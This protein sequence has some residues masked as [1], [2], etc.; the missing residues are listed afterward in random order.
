MLLTK[1]LFAP[2]RLALLV[3]KRFGGAK[4]G[5]VAHHDCLSYITQSTTTTITITGT[6]TTVTTTSLTIG[7]TTTPK[8]PISRRTF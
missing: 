5:A 2:R 4:H 1:R 3:Q 6:M 7:E 8:T